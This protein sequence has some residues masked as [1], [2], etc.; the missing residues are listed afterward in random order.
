MTTENQLPHWLKPEHLAW[1]RQERR[2]RERDEI[3]L[4]MGNVEKY[5]T[6]RAKSRISSG[7]DRGKIYYVMKLVKAE[8]A[9]AKSDEQ[10]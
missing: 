9:L 4:T 7:L 5:N 3:W 8:E 1:A 2:Q 10:S 6:L